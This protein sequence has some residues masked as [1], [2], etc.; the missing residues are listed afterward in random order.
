MSIGTVTVL[1]STSTTTDA[2]SF[3]VPVTGTPSSNALHYVAVAAW[4]NDGVFLTPSAVTGGGVTWTLAEHARTTNNYG[5]LSE[6]VAS[7]VPNGGD[8]TVSFE[9]TAYTFAAHLIQVTEAVP[10][11]FVQDAAGAGSTSA[12]ATLAG[13]VGDGN[14]TF[15]TILCLS[16]T[17]ALTLPTGATIVEAISLSGM[18]LV[19]FYTTGGDEVVAVTGASNNPKVVIAFEVADATPPPA[20]TPPTA[21]PRVSNDTPT[22]GAFFN[23][24]GVDSTDDGTI[25]S[26]GWSVESVTADALTPEDIQIVG[27]GANRTVMCP[28]TYS[29]G[30]ITFR[31]TVTDD[32]SLSSS[33]DV[34]VTFPGH[35]R[36]YRN[37]TGWEP[38]PT[39][40]GVAQTSD[41]VPIAVNLQAA[42]GDTTATL[43]WSVGP[44]GRTVTGV[45]IGRDGVSSTGGGPWESD[46]ISG[47]SGTLVFNNLINGTEYEVYVEPVVD[48]VRRSRASA[49]VTPQAATTPPGGGG[50]PGWDLHYS[51]TFAT[52]DGWTLLE[53]NQSNDNSRNLPKNVRFGAVGGGNGLIIDGIRESGY[54]RPYTS[55]EMHGKGAGLILPNYFRAEV[56]GR[57]MDERG[58]W[59]CLL[60]FRPQNASDGE[61]DVMEYMG[62]LYSGTQRRVAV[63][64][65][66]EYGGTQDPWKGPIYWNQLTTPSL[67]ATHKYTIEKTPGMLKVWVDDDTSLARYFGTSAE[68][69]SHLPQNG[70]SAPKAWWDRIMEVSSRTWY[71][72]ITL[73]IGDGSLNTNGKRVVPEPELTWTSSQME[74]DSLKFWTPAA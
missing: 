27:T 2:S 18:Q 74:I 4:R 56:I 3:T 33:E 6:W 30:Q 17:E 22:P 47:L 61:I 32:A 72:R 63:T 70:V 68:V 34:S 13:T 21:A 20:S 23:L 62:G 40:I 26:Y 54:S 41:E 65:H 15:G 69:L 35:P 60:W 12:T 46:F 43:D 66:N 57:V 73:Q 50:V 5:S 11:A 64:M 16:G 45:Y 51:T 19:T 37:A 39:V 9:T 55:G 7:G 59:P 10:G 44:S 71:S 1:G 52:N 42:P 25:V 48:G 38:L 31:L 14:A 36:W 53:E 8:L 58:L 67:T 49:L 29:G 28:H 24:I